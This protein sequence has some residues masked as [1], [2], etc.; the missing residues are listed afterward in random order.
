[1]TLPLVKRPPPPKSA[2]ELL[3]PDTNGGLGSLEM[4]GVM[5]L[6]GPEGLAFFF[7]PEGQKGRQSP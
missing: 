6:W 5:L 4:S 3:S 2:E 7:L 1:M